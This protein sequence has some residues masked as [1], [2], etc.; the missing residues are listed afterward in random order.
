MEFEEKMK[1]P[2]EFPAKF[3][4]EGYFK[5][6]SQKIVRR[7][8]DDYQRRHKGR[9]PAKMFITLYMLLDFIPPEHYMIMTRSEKEEIKLFGV[10]V[11]LFDGE[12]KQIYLS[13][14]EA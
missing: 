6:R 11:S 10:S 9:Y 12:G 14:E 1:F 2:L 13:D 4:Y 5:S 8:I 7:M 3:L